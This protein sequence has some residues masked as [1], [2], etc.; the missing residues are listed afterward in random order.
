MIIWGFPCLLT[1]TQAEAEPQWY[2]HLRS[3]DPYLTLHLAQAASKNLLPLARTQISLV[4]KGHTCSCEKHV[5][6]L[7]VEEQAVFKGCTYFTE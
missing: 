7:K 4:A 3:N 2:F 6:G 1:S 5:S